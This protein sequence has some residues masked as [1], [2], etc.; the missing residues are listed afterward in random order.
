[1]HCKELILEG[2]M[3][4]CLALM[5]KVW[6]LVRSGRRGRAESSSIQLQT[7][8][9]DIASAGENKIKLKFSLSGLVNVDLEQTSK[10]SILSFMV[11]RR[12]LRMTNHGFNICPVTLILLKAFQYL[13]C[14]CEEALA[15]LSEP[16]KPPNLKATELNC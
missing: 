13:P 10:G 15:S 6:T 3:F 2:L 1:M 4:S 7:L 11:L 8:L 16:F 9:P 12:S 5:S 14:R